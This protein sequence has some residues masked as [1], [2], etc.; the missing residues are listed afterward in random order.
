[1]LA[2]HLGTLH[3]VALDDLAGH[4]ER[5][6]QCERAVQGLDPMTD[7]V[8]Q[9]LRRPPDARP[10]ERFAA[11]A[12]A[13]P[14]LPTASHDTPMPGG[15]T[16]TFLAPPRGPGEIGWLA[17]YRI[18]SLLG[19]GGMGL[20]F[21]AEDTQLQRPV[22]LKV[23]KPQ[24]VSD[25]ISRHRFLREARAMA[26]VKSPYIVS[27]YHVGQDGNVPYL[28]MEFLQ[29]ETLDHWLKRTPRPDLASV[30][31]IGREVALGLTHAH[32]R[33]LIHR[34]IKPA[35]I[36]LSADPGVRSPDVHSP[37]HVKILDFGLA[38][39]V[40]EDVRLTQTGFV[41][42]TPA[43][44]APEQARGEVLDSRC[45]LFSLGCVLYRMTTGHAPFRG[46]TTMALLTALAIDQPKPARE[47]NPTVP[48]ALSDLLGKLLA[49][50]PMDRPK[51]A[52]A[53]ADMLANIN[54]RSATSLPRNYSWKPAL[55]TAAVLAALILLD[56]AAVTLI[57][58]IVSQPFSRNGSASSKA[59]ENDEAT[60]LAGTR[61][62]K[63]ADQ[64]KAVG[65]RLQKLNPAF[66]GQ[67]KSVIDE[68]VGVVELT[69]PTENVDDISPLRAFSNLRKVTLNSG[70][71]QSKLAN[72]TPLEGL[73]IT[74]L[75]CDFTKVT[76]LEPLKKLPLEKLSLVRSP[77]ADLRPLRGLGLKYLD[78]S[79]SE[80][81]DLAPV[82]KAPLV[83]LRFD[84]T[85]VD[86]LAPLKAMPLAHVSC[87]N[88]GVESLAPLAGKQLNYL[89]CQ[90]TKVRDFTAMKDMPLQILVAD[91]DPKRDGE[92]LKKMATL[93]MVNGMTAED[94]L[95]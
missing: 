16:Y 9:A 80:V 67:W 11:I 68:K 64:I 23:L 5:C 20:V 14:W 53:V 69:L 83:V 72:L 61:S 28:A 60:W 71:N 18:V 89:R 27:V 6:P 77:V 91:L 44:L 65:E 45:D 26:A 86:S 49:K 79:N 95:K 33:G 88:T 76:D 54:P 90:D 51:S 8:I 52:Q 46:E 2:F 15:E 29:G 17:H 62:L 84:H 78:V 31:R 21:Q 58:T 38:Q 22:A 7:P 74:D 19:T 3:G 82:E 75:N 25:D 93:K 87:N 63:P 35:N 43:Y 47:L 4:L 36:F 1:L 85:R 50:Y 81:A 39:A 12:L 55:I 57:G 41:S 59:A 30:L 48:P 42:G 56:L 92:W 66:D 94:F 24:L 32:E 40:T 10:D 70:G 34:D 73:P 13:G 37:F